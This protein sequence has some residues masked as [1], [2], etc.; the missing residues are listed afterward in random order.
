VFSGLN[1]DTRPSP[2]Q[3]PLR[4]K[5]PPRAS[6]GTLRNYFF[7]RLLGAPFHVLDAYVKKLFLF[8][9]FTVS[10]AEKNRQL[11]PHL[12]PSVWVLH[13]R[14]PHPAPGIATP[15]LSSHH[16]LRNSQGHPFFLPSL[17]WTFALRYDRLNAPYCV[18]FS[19]HLS[20]HRFLPF[21]HFRSPNYS[22]SF[23]SPFPVNIGAFHAFR[24][25][26][27]TS[28]DFASRRRLGCINRFLLKLCDST[29]RRVFIF[30]RFIFFLASPPRLVRAVSSLELS[31]TELTGG[32]FLPLLGSVAYV[33]TP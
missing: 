20:P 17:F 16:A 31:R 5:R 30:M 3:G 4:A 22:S 6:P 1:H 2:R 13:P 28:G 23:V 18:E 24:F 25:P 8:D 27:Q 21:S 33:L 9:S 11:R 26:G 10:A 32:H 29:N 7:V 12:P 14:P 15:L 19:Y